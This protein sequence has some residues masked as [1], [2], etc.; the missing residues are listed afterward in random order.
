[1]R[2][3]LALIAIIS[4]ATPGLVAAQVTDPTLGQ[5]GGSLTNTAGAAGFPQQNNQPAV[6]LTMGWVLMLNFLLVSAALL[7][8]I[9]TLYGGWLW[10]FARG[11][12]ELVNRGRAYMTQAVIGMLIVLSARIIV[13]LTVSGLVTQPQ[14]TAPAQTAPQAVEPGD[15]QIKPDS[16][17]G[18]WQPR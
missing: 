17:R 12:E 14:T 4:I 16:N 7:F 11:N 1:M 18:G 6:S 8:L 2:Y 13:E 10:M 9:I 5:I 15:L 3:L